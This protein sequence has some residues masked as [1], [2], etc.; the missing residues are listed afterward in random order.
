MPRGAQGATEACVRWRVLQEHLIPCV[1]GDAKASVART[2]EAPIWQAGRRRVRSVWR[3]R[4]TERRS[5][6][7]VAPAAQ[8]LVELRPKLNSTSNFRATFRQCTSNSQPRQDRRW[9][10]P[11]L[12]ARGPTLNAIAG[13]TSGVHRHR[14]RCEPRFVAP[15][16]L[17]PSP[18]S[19]RSMTRSTRSCWRPCRRRRGCFWP[20][21]K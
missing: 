10:P 17:N 21:S 14:H 18:G 9:S 2:M 3:E 6:R 15:R 13:R 8:R 4:R 11:G 7:N 19:L 12:G 5:L 16:E 1:G 20:Q